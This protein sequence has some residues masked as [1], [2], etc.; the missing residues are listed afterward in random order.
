MAVGF[1]NNS[2][3]PVE[4]ADYWTTSNKLIVDYIHIYQIDGQDLVLG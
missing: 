1:A 3:A 4:G 2:D